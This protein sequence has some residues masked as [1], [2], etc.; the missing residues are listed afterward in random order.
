MT[1]GRRCIIAL[2]YMFYYQT[3]IAYTILYGRVTKKVV[4]CSFSVFHFIFELL[5]SF[6][7]VFLTLMNSLSF[8]NF[9]K[10]RRGKKTSCAWNKIILMFFIMKMCGS[11]IISLPPLLDTAKIPQIKSSKAPWKQR[12]S[13]WANEKG[14]KKK[15]F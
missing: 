5:N 11:S 9:K 15:L 7:V 4:V 14:Q 8:F 1:Q 3:T 10:L 13:D 2:F 6:W 12:H